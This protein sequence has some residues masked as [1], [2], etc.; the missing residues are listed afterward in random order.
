M[1]LR[2]KGLT[3]KLL[4]SENFNP[5]HAGGMRRRGGGEG[6]AK[7]P[8]SKL[9]VNKPIN[10]ETKCVCKMYI[11]RFPLCSKAKL[12]GVTILKVTQNMTKK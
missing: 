9:S 11:L 2:S 3:D 6:V 5:A 8:T 4:F 1:T 7:I 10:L 12:E